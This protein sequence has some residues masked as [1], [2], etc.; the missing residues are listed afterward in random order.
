VRQIQLGLSID[1][2]FRR[3]AERVPLPE[4]RLFSAALMVQRRVGG[5]LAVTLERFARAIRE[6][7]AYRRQLRVAT[8]AGRWSTMVIVA[9]CLGLVV[10]LFGWQYD[11]VRSFL[12]TRV[13]QYVFMLAIILQV[14]GIVWVLALTR[15]EV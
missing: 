4:L 7:Q 10:Y 13:G 1:A 15:Y 2:T 9:A 14:I 12:E 11:Y 6:R 5:S 3:L 8:A